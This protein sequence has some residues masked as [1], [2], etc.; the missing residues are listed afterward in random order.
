M[1]EFRLQPVDCAE[2][3]SALK[4]ELFRVPVDGFGGDLDGLLIPVGCETN[5]PLGVAR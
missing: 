4:E 1:L 3:R 5:F 2:G